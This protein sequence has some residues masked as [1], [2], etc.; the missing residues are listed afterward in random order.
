MSNPEQRFQ[1][2]LQNGEVLFREGDP[3]GSMFVVRQ[4]MVRVSKHVR[5]GD[6]TLARLGPGEFFGEM[7]ILS[8]H[9]RSATV[10]A[11][12]A[13]LL[14]EVDAKRFETML[15]TQSEI[16]LRMIQ[17]LAKRLEVADAMIAILSQRDV[18][19]RV[20]L[21]LMREAEDNGLPGEQEGAVVV[22]RDLD[23]LSEALGLERRETDDVLGRLSRIGLV[24]AAEHGTEIPN[25]AKLGEFLEFVEKREG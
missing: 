4:G 17:N 22:P 16:A 10:T 12:G 3:P 13:A 23:D 15:K 21:G 18:K 2:E 20:I 9:A 19:T 11:E 5:G 14:V 24:R 7:A 1:R 6:K 8:G 25:L